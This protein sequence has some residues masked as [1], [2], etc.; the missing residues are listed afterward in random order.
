MKKLL[1]TIF[2]LMGVLFYSQNSNYNKIWDL[3]LRNK[4]AEARS[5]FDKNFL[6]KK[7]KELDALY[8]DAI[9]NMEE[10]KIS[11]DEEILKN[12]I[13]ISPDKNFLNANFYMPFFIGR[14]DQNGLD[15][16]FYKKIDLLAASKYGN[17][18]NV[19]YYKSYADQLRRDKVGSEKYANKIGYVNKW[20]FCGVFEN[21][22]GSGLDIE[23][24]PETYAKNDKKF[25]ANS[26]G[27][28][29]WYNV[30][31]VDKDVYHF[32]YNE[33]EYGEGIMFAQSFIEA[34]ED[35][36][37]Y[38]E[39]GCNAEFKAFLN[40]VEIVRS[41]KEFF[42]EKG[43]YLVKVKLFK[44]INRLLVKSEL[45]NSTATFARFT[46]KDSNMYSDLKY[47][48]TFQEYQ[49]RT[50][51]DINAEDQNFANEDFLLQK[52]KENPTSVS[53]KI[54][55]LNA[56]LSFSKNEKAHVLL[57]ELLKQY[58]QSSLL[59]VLNSNYYSSIKEN[60]KSLEIRKN[61]EINDPDY[62]Y[63]VIMKVSDSDFLKTGS[64]DELQKVRDLSAK[65]KAVV[66]TDLLDLM[67]QIRKTNMSEIA[68]RL[69]LLLAHSYN[70]ETYLSSFTQLYDIQKTNDTGSIQKLEKALE[71]RDNYHLQLLLAG[72]YI[73]ANRYN[74]AKKILLYLVNNYPYVNS[75]K[76]KYIE[77]LIKEK[78]YQEALDE[79]NKNL[80]NFP[81]SSNSLASKGIIYSNLN[82]KE[83]AVKCF[84]ASLSHDSS[85]EKVSHFLEDLTKK[86]NEIDNVATKD[87]YALAKE[88]RN[89][90]QKGELGVTT[91][92][93][94]YIVNV[95]EEGGL[96][97]R[98]TYVYEI[99][100]EAGIEELKEYSVSGDVKKAEIVKPN[101]SIV[102]GEENYGQLVFTNLE[103][104]D[105]VII[106]YDTV[107]KFTG[108]FY[109]DFNTAS[110]FNSF[111]PVVES[112]FVVI[113]PEELKYNVIYKNGTVPFTQKSLDGKK[114]VTWTLRNLPQ[115]PKQE[116][117]SKAYADITTSVNVGTLNSWKEIANWYSD[118]VKKVA[119][120]DKVITKVYNELFP[121]GV[122]NMTQYEIAEKIYN[123]IEKNIKY[124][125]VDF[126]QSGYIPQKPSKTLLSKLGDC[127]DLST[128][129]MVLAQQA[130]IQANLVL[131]S[132]N[133]NAKNYLTV[134][135]IDFNHCIVKTILDGKETYLEMTDKF[136]PFNAISR[137]NVK[138]QA[139]IIGKEK[140]ENEN[141]QLIEL[142]YNNNNNTNVALKTLVNIEEDKKTITATFK[143]FGESKAF[144]NDL[145][146]ENY[147]ADDRKS[148]IEEDLGNVINKVISAQYVNL[149]SG[150]DL[151][152]GPLVY[153]TKFVVSEKPQMVGS[154]K[155]T[156]IPFL[157]KPYTKDLIALENRKFDINY[158][159]YEN[160]NHYA[161]EVVINI[162][163]TSKFTE[164]P[165]NKELKYKAHVYSIKYELITPNQLKI[166]KEATPSWDNITVAEYPEFKKFVNEIL[167][168]EDQI[169]AYK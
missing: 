126:R 107:E 123:H 27:I 71:K 51:A 106:Q 64:M 79:V 154:L 31:D 17:E 125:S 135:T 10:G 87:L 76:D 62:Y 101:G 142:P 66:F 152:S 24:E 1:L 25:N 117:Y 156:Q 52:I 60:Q 5:L 77:I 41:S 18:L 33:T 168:L 80:E 16:T 57:E 145:F 36:V 164:I 55:L 72:E 130:G 151:S 30:K 119:V 23:Y 128:L 161:E 113:T 4:R 105:V 67:I 45:S 20:Q 88:R 49:K 157:V 110:Y 111:Y 116:T 95:F 3:L 81:Y 34:P 39:L 155:L 53:Y 44:G 140:S 118:L 11:F 103:V 131:V 35:R 50:S 21:L 38:L 82:N 93:D 59:N 65:T 169:I 40:D 127:K 100:S 75:Y 26:N 104:G 148:K 146:S 90:K 70:N 54:M 61:L 28:V 9:L 58:P 109:K 132:T 144:F 8:L 37:V 96:K 147:S 69:D 166:I 159:E 114:Y 78:K 165:E 13:S 86:S 112:T 120:S 149:I 121:N 141:A 85:N 7:D 29:G 108:R 92:L 102:P 122:K 94:E 115:I 167:Q 48:D 47:H 83:E 133:D 56:Y 162:P 98:S 137:T 2:C 99:T 63:N 68:P 15:D 32:Y 160:I 163:T 97:K 22:N 129:F 134:P 150:K 153:E 139:L 19:L 14:P 91:L 74:D 6:S 12:F 73:D 136:F 143:Y 138:A 89:T 124:S 46:D 158:I 43:N 84:K 42:N